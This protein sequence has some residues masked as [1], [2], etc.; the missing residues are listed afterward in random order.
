MPYLL[1]AE[2][3]LDP[4]QAAE[5]RAQ[6]GLIQI[7]ELGLV[8][9]GFSSLRFAVI[10]CPTKTDWA[11]EL[12]SAAGTI[13]DRSV[14]LELAMVLSQTAQA[15]EVGRAEMFLEAALAFES[16]GHAEE[17]FESAK[18][19]VMTSDGELGQ[20]VLFRTAEQAGSVDE[21]PKVFKQ[22]LAACKKRQERCF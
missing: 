16:A 18:Q 19:T 10:Q 21:L 7:K 12:I 11:Q 14:W 22:T 20:Q 2:H 3:V 15:V 6:A 1:A 4:D 8:R 13:D 5:H 17:A 9:E